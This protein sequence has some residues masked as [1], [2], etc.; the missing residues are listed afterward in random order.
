MG[1]YSAL[2]L[3]PVILSGG[4]GKRLW[5]L[6]RENYPK[7]FLNLSSE[8]YSLIQET[9]LRVSDSDT[10]APPVLVCNHDHRFLVAEKM[11]EIGVED[12]TIILEPCSRDTAPALAVAAE[13]IRRKYGEEAVMLVLPSD[14]IIQNRQAF[15]TGVEHAYRTAQAG[16]LTTFGIK[17]DRPETGYGYI[18][19]GESIDGEGI[20]AV[21]KFVEKPN[22]RK[23]EKYV[24][25]GDYLWNSGMFCFPV[26]LFLEEL[27]AH[28]PEMAA[29][30]PRI[31][32]SSKQDMD[33][34]R[35]DEEIFA[36]MPRNSIDYAVMEKTTRA[37]V[38]PMDC[39]WTDAGSWDALWRLKE[40][41]TRGNVTYGEG[42]YHDTED[43]YIW[44]KDG[45]PVTTLGVRDLVII[46]TKDCVMVADKNS[47]QNVKT[48]VEKVVKQAPELVKKYRQIYRPWGHYDSVDGGDRHQVKRIT[49]KPGASLSLQM[50]YHRSEHWIV[51]RGTAHVVCGDEQ[52]IVTEN[53]SVYIPSGTKH[54]LTNPG[55]IPLELIE[56]QSGPYLGEDDIVRF[57]DTYGRIRQVV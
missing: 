49:V 31:M 1:D 7:Q 23:A 20:F 44:S 53:E 8:K 9:A 42:H 22:H 37:A 45:V 27:N 33:F 17:P 13:Y 34:M 24:A 11:Q 57:E 28:Q 51:V 47:A 3:V 56:V 26:Q 55:K 38:V 18:K 30:L 16:Y 41:D 50:H 39:G 46:S 14:H 48:L 52:R 29:L 4:M 2:R 40:K 5:P 36:R 10:F 54:R 25:D 15:L 6:S 43:C 21:E 12:A 19:H 32:A 35:L